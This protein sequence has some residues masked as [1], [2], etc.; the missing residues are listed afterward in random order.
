MVWAKVSDVAYANGSKHNSR[1]S[2]ATFPSYGKG[3]SRK[4]VH[5]D[6]IRF[7]GFADAVAI[8]EEKFEE[9]T[10]RF[11][12]TIGEKTTGPRQKFLGMEFDYASGNVCLTQKFVNKLDKVSAEGVMEWNSFQSLIGLLG[13]GSMVANI[14]FKPYYYVIKFFRKMSSK[15]SHGNLLPN[16]K[17]FLWRAA[18]LQLDQWKADVIKNVPRT[19]AKTA[20]IGDIFVDAS[21]Y[22]YA[23]LMCI[24]G[25][26]IVVEANSWRDVRFWQNEVYRPP[27]THRENWVAFRAAEIIHEKGMHLGAFK[28]HEDNVSA[29]IAQ[30]RRFSKNFFMNEWA[31][32]QCA[33]NCCWNEV[34]RVPTEENIA[35][36]FSRAN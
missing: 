3:S 5:I 7:L 21:N 30:R 33:S 13:Y 19:T 23:V 34:L 12:V 1:I 17:V 20:L 22:G 9:I 16:Q 28:L 29:E 2:A 15:S 26:P 18:K 14:A 6:N 11:A 35:D 31:A 27:I 25:Q 10:K 4:D 36:A 24:R 8:A 32:Y